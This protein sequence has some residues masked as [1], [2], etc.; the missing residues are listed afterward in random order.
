MANW[1]VS[2][3]DIGYAMSARLTSHSSPNEANESV[4]LANIK[5]QSRTILVIENDPSP[6]PYFPKDSGQ[7]FSEVA[8]SLFSDPIRFNRGCGRH[9]GG[10]NYLFVD[11]H[12]RNMS[13]SEASVYFQDVAP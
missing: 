4:C 1:S 12:V 6:T 3:Y 9:N 7:S 2:D 10:A 11:G 8:S 13:P 5:D